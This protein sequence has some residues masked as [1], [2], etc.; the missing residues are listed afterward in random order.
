MTSFD[1]VVVAVMNTQLL[2]YLFQLPKVDC[3]IHIITAVVHFRIAR[4]SENECNVELAFAVLSLSL[5]LP[6]SECAPAAN[7]RHKQ[8]KFSPLF[9]FSLDF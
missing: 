5:A 6:L 3:I 9:S 1:V 2:K 4:L 7:K 8:F